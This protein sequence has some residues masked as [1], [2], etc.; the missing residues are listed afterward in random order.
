[1]KQR[2][3][4]IF[5]LLITVGREVGIELDDVSGKLSALT[6]SIP[7]LGGGSAVVAAALRRTTDP[8]RFTAIVLYILY[9]ERPEA[10]DYVANR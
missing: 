4:W 1:M 7:K 5:L 9:T 6:K 3:T 10:L 2:N 8:T